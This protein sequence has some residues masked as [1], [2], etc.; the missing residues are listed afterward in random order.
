MS[1]ANY[2]LCGSCHTKTIYVGEADHEIV[3]CKKCFEQLQAENKE[4]G[5]F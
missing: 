3:Y 4:C 5:R 1:G 2:A